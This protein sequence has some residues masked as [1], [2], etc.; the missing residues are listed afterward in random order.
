ME[1]EVER[2]KLTKIKYKMK[3]GARGGP[4]SRSDRK[5]PT[6]AK[7]EEADPRRGGRMHTMEMLTR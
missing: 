6:E 4:R 7:E 3:K 1:E 2:K 5:W